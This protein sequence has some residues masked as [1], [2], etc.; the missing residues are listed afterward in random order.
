M[1]TDNVDDGGLATPPTTPPALTRAQKLQNVI[2][3][4]TQFSV[5]VEAFN[6]IHPS[7]DSDHSQKVALAKL[8]IQQGRLLI[9]GDAV[10]I[11]SPPAT[12]A[13][14]MIPSHPGATNPDPHLP[15]NF[16]VRHPKLDDAD[17]NEKVR[18]ALTEISGRPS[19]ISREE[20]MERYGLKTPKSFKLIDYPALDTNRLEAFREKYTLL[21][22]LARQM[23]SRA[24]VR[25]SMSMT[26]QYWTVKDTH[27]F[28]S[29]VATVRTEVDG[30]IDLMDAKDQVDRGMKSDIRSM[31]W[32]PDL[33]S[34]AVRQD[35]E[36]LR[37]IREACAEDY[38]EYVS[39]T[40]T[41]LKYISEEL[42]GTTL[43]GF[44][45]QME[46]KEHQD[47]AN[48]AARRNSS[49]VKAGSGSGTT[50][51][52]K[53]KNGTTNG[54]SNGKEKRPGWLSAFKFKS[55]H[56][57]SSK[58]KQSLAPP[59]QDPP[60]SMSEAM[61]KAEPLH[62]VEDEEETNTLEPVRSKS[63]SALPDEG[64]PPL[65]LE[66]RLENI[67][68]IDE[69]KER[70]QQ[71]ASSTDEHAA[72]INGLEPASTVNSLIDRHDMWKGVGR[73][74]TKDIRGK[75]HDWATGG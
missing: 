25:R 20:L 29:F 9:F 58:T 51:P 16:G 3:L 35:W 67:P 5:C 61:P 53:G 33:S 26:T 27:R 10:G 30:L 50:T 23:G 14:H 55:W 24:P 48:A 37:L 18:A 52:T 60:R 69:E 46:L 70:Q 31:G 74:E 17:I 2:S 6:Q 28:D 43:A 8:G 72:G 57:S 38:P 73:V 47:A 13:K 49:D 75:A 66:T 15:V 42:K 19:Q 11:S 64:P 63:L 36:K 7:K 45:E 54:H 41:A 40:D 4:A 65:D 1:A 21:Q 59:G 39:A 62:A 44:R 56:K 32:H 34:I 22:D 12:I 68:T 71:G